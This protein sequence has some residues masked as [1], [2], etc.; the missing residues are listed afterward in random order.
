MYLFIYF[1]MSYVKPLQNYK[2]CFTYTTILVKKCF[3]HETFSTKKCFT[4]KT[5]LFKTA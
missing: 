1:H 3:T 2:K 5:H 4:R